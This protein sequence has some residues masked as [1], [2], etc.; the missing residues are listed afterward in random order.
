[1]ITLFANPYL[2]TFA[3]NADFCA[4]LPVL[5]VVVLTAAAELLCFAGERVDGAMLLNGNGG[6]DRHLKAQG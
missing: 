2:P 3:S 4:R 1:M 5:K 6:P